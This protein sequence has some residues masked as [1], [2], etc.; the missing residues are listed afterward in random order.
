M[1]L[2]YTVVGSTLGQLSHHHRSG[3]AADQGASVTAELIRAKK[4][5]C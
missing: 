4:K 3:T 5:I 2:F 1:G